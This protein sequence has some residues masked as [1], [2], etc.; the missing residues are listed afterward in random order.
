MQLPSSLCSKKYPGQG[1]GK[2]MIVDGEQDGGKPV[3][4]FGVTGL[5]L[6]SLSACHQNKACFLS[7]QRNTPFSKLGSKLCYF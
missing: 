4:R 2:P 5:C 3:L 1:L 7:S 6:P